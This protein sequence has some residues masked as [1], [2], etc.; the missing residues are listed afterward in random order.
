MVLG[1]VALHCVVSTPC[2]VMVVH[3]AHRHP[4]DLPAQ[5]AAVPADAHG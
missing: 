1:S 5:R 4:T 2:P 3:P